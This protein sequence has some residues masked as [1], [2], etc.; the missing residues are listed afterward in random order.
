MAATFQVL[1]DPI[2]APQQDAV[3]RS[4]VIGPIVFPA[5]TTPPH[6]D[7]TPAS[8]FCQQAIDR[9]VEQFKPQPKIESLLCLLGDR[10]TAIEQALINTKEFRQIPMALG[11]QL[12]ELGNLY[13]EPRNAETDDDYR[14]RLAASAQVVD[15]KGTGEDLLEV[16]VALDNG[17]DPSSISLV[18]HHPACVILTA[19][20]PLGQQLLGET[21]GRFLQRAKAGGVCLVL[22]FEEADATIFVWTPDAGLGFAE[23]DDLA[24]TGAIWAEGV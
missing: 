16:L 9:I 22:L 14:R 13:G 3:Q 23:E 4:F 21:M 12:D 20:V 15:S 2:D 8:D 6:P 7:G 19:K 5:S 24:G 17:F 1:T 18:E 11:S 10:A